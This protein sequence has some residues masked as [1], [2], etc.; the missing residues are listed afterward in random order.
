MRFSDGTLG[1]EPCPASHT[2]DI[3]CSLFSVTVRLCVQAS[4]RI[5]FS[6]V[7]DLFTEF[8]NIKISTYFNSLVDR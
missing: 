8:I 1:F 5:T 2:T 4:I 7:P 3:I 6:M